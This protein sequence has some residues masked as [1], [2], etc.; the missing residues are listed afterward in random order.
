MEIDE[1]DVSNVL[2]FDLGGEQL[3][4]KGKSNK[5]LKKRCLQQYGITTKGLYPKNIEIA[6]RLKDVQFVDSW[7]KLDF[8]VLFYSILI[9]PSNNTWFHSNIIKCL[10]SGDEIPRFNWRKFIVELLKESKIEWMKNKMTNYKGPI[11]FLTM[12]YADRLYNSECYTTRKWPV[13]SYMTNEY[14]ISRQKSDIY[15]NKFGNLKLLDR[16]F[17]AAR[18][19]IEEIRDQMSSEVVQLFYFS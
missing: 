19:N 7:F 9:S 17:E 11:L 10:E 15:K 5:A 8:L 1:L 12:L 6:Q 18:E 13:I 14:L 3:I 2:G 4:I 16:L